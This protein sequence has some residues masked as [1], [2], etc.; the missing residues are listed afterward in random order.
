MKKLEPAVGL[1]INSDHGQFAV[2]SFYEVTRLNE[3]GGLSSQGAFST[4]LTSLFF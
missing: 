1:G 4:S 2:G 3:A